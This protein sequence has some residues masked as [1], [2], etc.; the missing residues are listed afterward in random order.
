M[1]KLYRLL[2][3]NEHKVVRAIS[4]LKR[5]SELLEAIDYALDGLPDGWSVIIQDKW[6][7]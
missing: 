3:R 2:V 7:E 1:E 6:G 4:A 5:R